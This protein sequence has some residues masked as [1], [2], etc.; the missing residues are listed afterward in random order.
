MI[1][2]AV[3]KNLEILYAF[4]VENMT[5]PLDHPATP[6][7][8]PRRFRL[9]NVSSKPQGVDALVEFSLPESKYMELPTTNPAYSYK[10]YRYAYGVSIGGGKESII[11]DQLLKL[12]MDH[13][14]IAGEDVHSDGSACIWREEHCFP[15]EPIFVANPD[16]KEEDDGVVLSVVLDGISTKSMLVVLDAKDMKELARAQMDITFPMGFHGAFVGSRL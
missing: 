5:H 9:R 7:A 4:Q 3:Y 14:Q 12:D 6:K 11:S 13:P 1:D 15:G 16:G 8:T 2:L 10:K